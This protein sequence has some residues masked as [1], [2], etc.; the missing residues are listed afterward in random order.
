[1]AKQQGT[2]G[3]SGTNAPTWA[4]ALGLLAW[5]AITL[6]GVALQLP[7]EVIVLRALVGSVAVAVVA[8]AMT[9]GWNLMSPEDEND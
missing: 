7:P 2:S 6:I 9:L 4:L 8:V 3:T 5:C 1:M